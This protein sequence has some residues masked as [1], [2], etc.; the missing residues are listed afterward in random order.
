[1]ISKYMMD[2]FK[3]EIEV[4]QPEGSTRELKV[5]IEDLKELIR[6]YELWQSYMKSQKFHPGINVI[7][8][9]AKNMAEDERL[10]MV[11]PCNIE[12]DYEKDYED[13]TD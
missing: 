9:C 5:D 13:G 2:Y 11:T 6:G 8:Q 10:H 4:R 3:N 12:D 7:S 1:M